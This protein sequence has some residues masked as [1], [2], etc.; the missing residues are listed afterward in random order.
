MLLSPA[1]GISSFPWLALY[2]VS[3][4]CCVLA[5]QFLN[6]PSPVDIIIGLWLFP[7]FGAT[8]LWSSSIV[9]EKPQ[10]YDDP[11]VLHCP[12]LICTVNTGL[13]ID[14][15]T[16]CSKSFTLHSR[17]WWE[18]SLDASCL[19]NCSNTLILLSRAF[20][21]ATDGRILD[22]HIWQDHHH[23]YQ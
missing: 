17:S 12:S 11:I 23:R 20:T 13:L 1:L 10:S 7:W 18:A 6:C 5:V 15:C 8:F 22:Y 2:H 14:S 21:Y 3:M 16:I 9:H 19:I 4:I